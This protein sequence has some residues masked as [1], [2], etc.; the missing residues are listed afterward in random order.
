MRWWL[1]TDPPRIMSVDNASVK[2][3][4]FSSLLVTHPDLWMVHWT[5]GMGEIERQ[6]VDNDANLNGLREGF[7]DVTPYAP[8]FQQF[9]SKVPG[10]LLNQAKK[11]QI[12]LIKQLF[13]SKRQLPFHYVVSAGDYWWDATDE[14][15]YA[16]TSAGLQNA[17]ASINSIAVRLNSVV[18]ALNANDAAIV[19][20]ANA[21]VV[22][23]G[24]NFIN[25]VNAWVVAPTNNGFDT[26][27]AMFGADDANVN[28]FNALVTYVNNTVLGTLLGDGTLNPNDINNRLVSYGGAPMIGL[29]TGIAHS[30]QGMSYVGSNPYRL[31]AINQAF[32][33]HAPA[34]VPW[35][36]LPNV[37]TSNVQWI[38]IGGSAPVNVTPA[39]QTAIMNGIA[40]RT[41]ALNVV[42]NAKIAEVNA[43]TIV[44]AVINYD[45]LAGWPVI[46]VPPGYVQTASAS[47]TSSATIIGTFTG[48][49][50]TGG[51]VPE[52]PS[53]GVTYGRRNAAWNPAL[54]LSGDILDGG[55]F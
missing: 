32:S 51:G 53:D 29:S 19:A 22:G 54:A 8:L 33:V 44:D 46:A 52:A 1:Q 42:R 47:R 7:F 21:Y 45:V 6:D 17:I 20:D 39:E 13:E 11:I 25:Q 16:S 12:D 15:L 28:Q 50:P 2:G 9:L 27:A 38:P 26:I 55:N 23:P 30:G 48:G 24:N 4:D 40:A 14:T 35:T 5:D 3:M 41:N 31:T 36:A 43:L 34:A 18:P 49:P 37:T 10:L